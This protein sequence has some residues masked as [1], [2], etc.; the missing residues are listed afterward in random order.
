MSYAYE[1][2]PTVTIP[3]QL[4][5]A[6]SLSLIKTTLEEQRQAL[7]IP[8]VIPGEATDPA[9]LAAFTREHGEVAGRYRESYDRVSA[10]LATFIGWA[11]ENGIEFPEELLD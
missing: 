2:E 5:R 8:P 7:A 3:E 1:H 4:N 6:A 11:I 9:A 10:R